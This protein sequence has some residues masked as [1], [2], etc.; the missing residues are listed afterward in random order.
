MMQLFNYIGTAY[1]YQRGIENIQ[2]LSP[3]QIGR[4]LIEKPNYITYIG[5]VNFL[6]ACMVGPSFQFK[7]F[8]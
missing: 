2:Y 4:R 6:P 5:Y 8:D 1:N 3:E 7:D